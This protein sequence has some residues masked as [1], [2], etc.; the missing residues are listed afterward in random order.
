MTAIPK[1]MLDELAR[2]GGKIEDV[3]FTV[4]QLKEMLNNAQGHEEREAIK[5]ALQNKLLV[6]G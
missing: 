3:E 4:D 1:T 2:T 5:Q 6:E